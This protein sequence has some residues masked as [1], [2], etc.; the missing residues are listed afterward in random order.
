MTLRISTSFLAPG[1]S[2]LPQRG[3]DSER[4]VLWKANP[5]ARQSSKSIGRESPSTM[6][7]KHSGGRGVGQL[8]FPGA[9]HVSRFPQLDEKKERQT[10]ATSGL[11]C[12]ASF[13]RYGRLG[14]LQRM[15]LILPIWFSP[16]AKMIWRPRATKCSHLI[17][18]LAV[19]DYQRWNGTS[20][21]LPRAEASTWKGAAKNAYRGNKKCSHASGGRMIKMLRDSPESPIYVHPNFIEAVKGFPIGWT[22]IKCSETPSSRKSHT[23][24]LRQSRRSKRTS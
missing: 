23:R 21:L 2:L 22:D 6:T 15:L 19:V 16:I 8:S 11:I 5:S 14:L 12:C 4:S 17:F 24:S 9:S 10:I 1:P 20:G 18:Q 7:S 13:P 3:R